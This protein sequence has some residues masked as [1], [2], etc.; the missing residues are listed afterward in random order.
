MRTINLLF[1]LTISIYGSAQESDSAYFTFDLTKYENLIESENHFYYL[2]DSTKVTLGISNKEY[3]IQLAPLNSQFSTV[4]R[5]YI[6]T[7]TLKRSIHF[8][9]DNLIGFERQYDE[10]LE[11]ISEHDWE[12]KFPFSFEDLQVKLMSDY[13]I[14]I[15][16]NNRISVNRMSHSK[17]YY[18]IAYP[19]TESPYGMWKYLQFDGVTGEVLIDIE[20]EYVGRP[21]Q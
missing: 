3:F 13:A 12:E 19:M 4:Y 8:F 21:N 17:A 9:H 11:L 16:Q 15:L 10:S 6:N 7:L 18:N 1:L 2:E 5:Y 14:D 20:K